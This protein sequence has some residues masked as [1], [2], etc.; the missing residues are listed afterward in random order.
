MYGCPAMVRAVGGGDILLPVGERTEDGG[1]IREG[2]ECEGFVI[3]GGG[4]GT[5][6]AILVCAKLFWCELLGR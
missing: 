3:M 1:G 6:G 2:A 4:T 5:D